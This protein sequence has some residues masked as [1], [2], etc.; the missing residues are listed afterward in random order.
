[1]ISAIFSILFIFAT[2]PQQPETFAKKASLGQEFEVRLGRQVSIEHEGLTVAFRELLEDSRCP[3]GVTCV[4]A[5]NGKVLLR[6][7]KAG[8][9]AAL[10]RLNTGLDPRQDAYKGYDVKLVNLSP[11]PKKDVRIKKRGYVATLIVT[12]K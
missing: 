1:M 10:M 8:K 3:Q 7:S 6:L 4:W 9:R 11:Y 5:G 12:R 2:A